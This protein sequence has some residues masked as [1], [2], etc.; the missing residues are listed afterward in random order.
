MRT[1]KLEEI[2]LQRAYR[3]GALD[4]LN[5]VLNLINTYE[6]QTVEKKVVYRDVFGIRVS[7]LQNKRRGG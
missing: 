1:S 7:D 5:A 3:D 4:A 6:D 2:A